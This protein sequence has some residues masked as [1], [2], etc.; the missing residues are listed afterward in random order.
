MEPVT[1]STCNDVL[2]VSRTQ[3]DAGVVPLP[4]VRTEDSYGPL[5]QSFWKPDATELKALNDGHPVMLEVYGHTHAPLRVSVA[6]DK[7]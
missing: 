4:I 1:H 5:I 6:G 7:E 3:T 2:G